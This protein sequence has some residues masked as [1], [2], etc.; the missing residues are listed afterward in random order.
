MKKLILV[1]VL[2][3]GLFTG[4]SA[5]ANYISPELEKSLVRIC[6]A[7]KS[8]SR[9][10]L[11]VAIKD[12]GIDVRRIMKGLVCNGQDPINFARSNRANKTGQL[13]AA[14]VNVDYSQKLAKR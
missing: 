5:H 2:S 4:G 1:S 9:I 11:H 3:L 10:R 8:D 13:L 14:R 12:S 6:E 7:I